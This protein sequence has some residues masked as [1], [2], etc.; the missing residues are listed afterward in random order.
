M[1]NKITHTESHIAAVCILTQ[2][3]QWGDAHSTHK[4][5]FPLVALRK[6]LNVLRVLAV[7]DKLCC[8]APLVLL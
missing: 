5:T 1:K 3:D 8:Q 6:Y 7:W 4:N 2:T